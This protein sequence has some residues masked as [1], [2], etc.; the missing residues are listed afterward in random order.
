MPY[1]DLREFI[2]VLEK[3]GDAVRVEK[4]V[5]ANLEVGAITRRVNETQSPAPFFQKIKGYGLSW[6]TNL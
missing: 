4:E 5:D 2:A 1:K 3:Q 6:V